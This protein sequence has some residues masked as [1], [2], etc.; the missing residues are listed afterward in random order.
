MLIP[1]AIGATDPIR[2]PSHSHG[3]DLFGNINDEAIRGVNFAGRLTPCRLPAIAGLGRLDGK[4]A[5]QF[6]AEQAL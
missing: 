4:L 6:V 5:D 2:R 3:D 1:I